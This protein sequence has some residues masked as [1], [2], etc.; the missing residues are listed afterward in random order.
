[1]SKTSLRQKRINRTGWLFM[2]P[3][4]L[5]GI[6]FLV[7]PIVMCFAFS[8]TDFYML[9]PEA[10]KFTFENYANVFQDALFGKAI[11]NTLFFVVITVPVQCV[12][13][14]GLAL[15]VNKTYKGYGI[16]KLAYFAPVI[17]SMTVVSLLFE[18]LYK[19][20]GGVFNLILNTFG[21]ASQGFL[22]DPAQAMLC[23]IFMSVWQGAGYQMIIILAGLQGVSKELYEAADI[24]GAS[25]WVKFTHITLPGIAPIA[26]FV[27]VIT[28]VGAF[29]MFTQVQ[30]LTPDGGVD[31]STITI[32]YYIFQK[33][34]DEKLVGYG[35]AVSILFTVV[36]ILASVGKNYASKGV[37][38]YKRYRAEVIGG[39]Y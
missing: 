14:L 32:V 31:Y 9:R 39:G 10:M 19:E 18:I 38:K 8:F 2:L 37:D 30:I 4:V 28:L 29:K 20:E 27:L 1:M 36:F 7:V 34:M 5:F 13:A 12:L 6:V 15:L 21:I 22:N 35:A 23:I 11:A 16:F 33:G 25:P 26:S 17:T 3:A 24:D